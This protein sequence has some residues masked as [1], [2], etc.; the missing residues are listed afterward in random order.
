MTSCYKINNFF[1]KTTIRH[2][3][4]T[5]NGPFRDFYEAYSVPPY[6]RANARFHAGGEIEEYPL[7][8]HTGK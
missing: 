5:N 3:L 7:T 1:G 4:I 6:G 2:I 8:R